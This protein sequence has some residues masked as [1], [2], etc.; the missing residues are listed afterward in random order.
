MNNN[1]AIIHFKQLCLKQGCL[2]WIFCYLYI[3]ETYKVRINKSMGKNMEAPFVS[4][5]RVEGK[6]PCRPCQ[7]PWQTL[8]SV[9]TKRKT[10]SFVL[11]YC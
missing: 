1:K 9:P 11:L 7:T 6:P 4:G 10:L 5:V 3:R 2:K 8:G